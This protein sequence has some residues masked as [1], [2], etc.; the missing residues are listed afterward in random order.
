MKKMQLTENQ[1]ILSF[2]EVA[3][4]CKN[5]FKKQQLADTKNA[6]KKKKASCIFY[7]PPCIS[8]FFDKIP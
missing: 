6:K 8:F 3:T 1:V 5:A 4:C 7:T 2:A